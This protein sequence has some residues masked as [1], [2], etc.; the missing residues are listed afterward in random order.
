MVKKVIQWENGTTND[1]VQKRGRRR[2]S[3]RA[4]PGVVEGYQPQPRQKAKVTNNAI[5]AKKLPKAKL[6]M[7]NEFQSTSRFTNM[8]QHRVATNQKFL[9]PGMYRT[10]SGF[11]MITSKHKYPTYVVGY[12]YY[13]DDIPQDSLLLF[14]KFVIVEELIREVDSFFSNSN[15]PA[16]INAEHALFMYNGVPIFIEDTT[17][18]ERV[19]S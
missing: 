10:T 19:S 8:P 6:Q 15:I 17:C 13:S 3:H 18:L 1:N 12:G 4:E 9:L 7:N 2:K 14:I 11:N 5:L 16:T